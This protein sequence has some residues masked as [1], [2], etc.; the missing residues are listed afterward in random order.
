MKLYLVKC[1]GMQTS[2]ASNPIHGM[3]Y[4]VANDPQQAYEQLRASLAK[5]DIGYS[6]DRE[7]E[8]V[9]LLAEEGYYPE[10]GMKLYLPLQG[11]TAEAPAMSLTA[12]A[13]MTL[14]QAQEITD[15]RERVA[16]LEQELKIKKSTP[17]R[18]DQ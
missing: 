4:V 1:R 6:K 12:T 14:D 10:C 3:A 15:L 9:E 13:S 16:R 2:I 7:L 8:S 18:R 11:K 17:V 5:K